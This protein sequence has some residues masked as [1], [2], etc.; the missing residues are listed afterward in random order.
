MLY[1]FSIIIRETLWMEVILPWMLVFHLI[2]EMLKEDNR[3]ITFVS[4]EVSCYSFFIFIAIISDNTHRLFVV[5]DSR[6]G[7]YTSLFKEEFRTKTMHITHHQFRE[8]TSH[9]LLNTVGHLS[10]STVG[11]RKTKHILILHTPF[12]CV[13]YPLCEDMC[14][15]T[16]RRCQHKMIS[17]T[18]L[19]DRN[20]IFI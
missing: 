18:C 9:H 20:L 14:L 6:I 16:S 19:N 15:T 11:E 17:L 12:S 1:S 7:W 4:V 13:S 2:D 8:I 5:N 10:C 3:L